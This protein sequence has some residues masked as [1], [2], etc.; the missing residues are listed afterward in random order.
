MWPSWG[1]G[2]SVINNRLRGTLFHSVSFNVGFLKPPR[3]HAR[4][5]GIWHKHTHT[6]TL[7]HKFW[8]M[9]RAVPQWPTR[10]IY[11]REAKW[12]TFSYIFRWVCEEGNPFECS[13]RTVR[14][15]A[16]WWWCWLYNTWLS[17]ATATES[18]RYVQLFCT[19]VHVN[20]HAYTQAVVVSHTHVEKSC[21]VIKQ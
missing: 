16:S 7:A 3:K 15:V 21:F 2:I 9:V 18:T 13:R 5:V 8:F 4:S 12:V 19:H 11:L 14:R 20:T 17:S 1:F 6:H 10:V